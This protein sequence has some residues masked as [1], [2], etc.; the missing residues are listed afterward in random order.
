VADAYREYRRR[1]HQ[2]RLQGAPSAR[3]DAEPQ[4]AARAAVAELWAAV[5]GDFWRNGRAPDF[6]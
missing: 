6:G 5:F 2:I 4:R 1:Q 3:V